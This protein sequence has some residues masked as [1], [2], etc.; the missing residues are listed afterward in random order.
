[1]AATTIML[2]AAAPPPPSL[3]HIIWARRVGH[4]MSEAEGGK[5]SSGLG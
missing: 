5:E 2:A 4:V 1:M 3:P